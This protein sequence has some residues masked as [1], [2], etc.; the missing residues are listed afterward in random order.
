MRSAPSAVRAQAL[1]NTVQVLQSERRIQLRK[2]LLLKR[3]LDME[4]IQSLDKDNNGLD[5]L[6]FVVGMVRFAA[7]CTPCRL[8][9]DICPW[10]R[11]CTWTRTC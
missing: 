10:T 6:E 3:Q 5:K 11:T 9:M 1:L 2:G 7:A 4:L 8:D